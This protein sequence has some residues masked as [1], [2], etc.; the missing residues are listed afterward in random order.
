MT[1]IDLAELLCARLCHDLI[2]PV[3]AV[4]NGVEMVLMAPGSSTED[5]QLISDSIRAAQAKL[6]FYRVAFGQ[7]GGGDTLMSLAQLGQIAHDYFGG[8][9]LALA[10]PRTGPDLPRAVAKLVLLML[11]TGASAAP[12]GG[13]MVLATPI[14]APLALK[15][16]VEG[17]RVGL[18]PAAMPVVRGEPG[19]WPEAPR[20]AHLALLPRVAAAV[21]ADVRAEQGEG[22]FGLRVAAA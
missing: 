7:R 10:L 16:E 13:Q 6:V 22:R 21:G 2:S 9:R 4:S 1:D 18:Q 8:G 5:M 19:A 15:L 12:R 14:V 11:L 3:S 17:D 20:E